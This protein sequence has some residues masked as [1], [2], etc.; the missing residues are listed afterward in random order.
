M[1]AVLFGNS[2]T[3]SGLV[4]VCQINKDTRMSATKHAKY[5]KNCLGVFQGG[6]C[7]AIAFVG[8][9]RKA[10]EWR[11][12]FSEVSGTSA[13]SIVAA[14]VA[15]G[16]TPDFLEE[17]LDALDFNKFIS[18]PVKNSHSKRPRKAILKSLSSGKLKH[19]LDLENYLG[20]HSSEYRSLDGSNS[21][22]APQ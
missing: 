19:Y 3:L 6:G 8:A 9:Y 13:G 11:V 16:A 10:I 21:K 5:F 22:D 20:L 14:L 7:K 18:P 1:P 12:F 4:V 17:H 2:A 15:A